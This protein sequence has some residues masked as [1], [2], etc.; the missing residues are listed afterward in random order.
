M[1]SLAAITLTCAL[2]VSATVAATPAGAGGDQRDVTVRLVTHDS[3]SVSKSVLRD[4][5]KQTG[6]DV[7][8]L[9]SGDGGSA[10]N[11]AILTKDEPIGD[12]LFGVD[13]TFLSRALDEDIFLPARVPNLNDV[14]DELRLDDT[15]RAIP[16]DHGAVCVNYDKQWYADHDEQVPEDLDDLLEH[17]DRLVVEN[18]A[19]ST[20]GLPFLLAT[21]DRY[22][23]DGWRDYWAKLRDGGVEVVNGWEEAFNGSFSGGEGQGDKPLVVSYASSPPVAVHFSDPQP[24]ESPIGTALGTCFDQIEF[25][26]VLKGTD[27][28]REARQLVNFM[29]SRRFQEDVPLQMFVFPARAGTKLPP[30]FEKFADVPTDPATLPPDDIGA[31]RE[32]WIDQWTETV[33][34]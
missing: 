34:R 14:P 32:E 21:I 25:A 18:P 16:I 13:N 29:L 2:V 33:L 4:F 8:V 5:T 22:G 9:P 6:V 23:E 20:A 12:V 27:H 3:F 7:E 30:V 1:R 19:T 11:Q 26:G 28:P 24:K 15:D 17:P 31:H 10:L